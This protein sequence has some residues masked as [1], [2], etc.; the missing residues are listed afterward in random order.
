MNIDYYNKDH[1]GGKMFNKKGQTA[2]EYMIILAVVIIIALI[3]VGV[4]GGIPGIGGAAGSR[5]LDSYWATADIAVTSAAAATTGD[6][7]LVI[8]NN[9]GNP[10]VIDEVMLSVTGDVEPTVG[11]DETDVTLNVGEQKTFNFD[12]TGICTEVAAAWV[13]NMN[14]S[15]RDQSTGATYVF[16][17]QGNQ[18][19]GTCASSIS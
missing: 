1:R 16:T 6:V 18:L 2:T 14:V 10:I 8:R 15:Y 7:V 5:T 4:L 19:R 9:V 12:V 17:G 3:V 11:S 13:S